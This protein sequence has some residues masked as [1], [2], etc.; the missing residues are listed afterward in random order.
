[1]PL[2]GLD[3]TALLSAQGGTVKISPQNA[4]P[5]FRQ[6]LDRVN[7]D[8]VGSAFQQLGKIIRDFIRNSVGGSGYSRALEAIRVMREEATDLEV[9]G[10][11]NEWM[12]KLKT[13]ILKEELNGDRKDMWFMIRANRMGLIQGKECSS[14]GV[15]EDEAKEFL[16]VRL[17][18]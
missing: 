9:P 4:V 17:S 13:E 16:S 1:M 11:Y 14:S 3:V 18:V 2:S 10:F 5:E 15:G 12:K 7:H 6:A 8:E